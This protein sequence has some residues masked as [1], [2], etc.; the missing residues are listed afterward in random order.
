MFFHTQPAQAFG[1]GSHT[2]MGIFPI[3]SSFPTTLYLLRLSLPLFNSPFYL[4]IHGS[5]PAV[6]FALSFFLSLC[7]VYVNR[8]FSLPLSLSSRSLFHSLSLSGSLFFS[9]YLFL[10]SPSLTFSLCIPLFSLSRPLSFLSFSLF[11]TPSS[12]SPPVSM[13][14]FLGH[15]SLS[16]ALSPSFSLSFA[17][18][19]SPSFS[20][21]FALVLSL[22]PGLL[23]TQLVRFY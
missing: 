23:I 18:A 2:M 10:H 16:L 20:L 7:P 9:L 4:S 11:I 5:F 3:S 17:L 8:S 6:F 19:L 12:H 14:F 21:S 22:N 13:C 1:P 15:S